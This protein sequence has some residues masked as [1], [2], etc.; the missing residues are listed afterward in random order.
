MSTPMGRREL[1]GDA[2]WRGE[3]LLRRKDWLHHLDEIEL[4]EVDAW[5][6][7]SKSEPNTELGPNISHRLSGVQDRLENGAGATMIRGLDRNRYDQTQLERL[8]LK[9]ASQLGTPLSQS[10]EGQL[11]FSVRNAG[12]AD[13]DPRARGPNTKKKLSFH[14]DR[15]DVIGFL[16]IQPAKSGGENQLV[17]S[18][19]LFNEILNQ[20]P[21]LLEQLMQPYCYQRHGFDTAN[22]LPYTKQPIFSFFEGKFAANFLR[23][24]IERAHKNPELPPMTELQIEALDFL[25][26]LADQPGM[27]VTFR[28][29]PGDIVFMNNWITLHRRHEF[30]DDDD[31]KLRRHILRVWLSMPNSRA[32]DPRFAGNYGATAAGAI[33]GGIKTV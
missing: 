2:V 12:F 9:L 8:F 29:Q 13:A 19:A 32:V 26:L 20:R 11:V 14:T 3:E 25:E 24:L 23:V 17:S 5:I 22:E 7:A 1:V 4:D 30:E 31:P 27:H 28:Q 33:R 21:D 16:C 15:C 6:D 18:A 10:A